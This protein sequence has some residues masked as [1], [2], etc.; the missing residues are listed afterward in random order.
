MKNFNESRVPDV[1]DAKVQSIEEQA[2]KVQGNYLEGIDNVEAVDLKIKSIDIKIQEKLN[3]INN[4]DEQIKN[5]AGLNVSDLNDKKSSL[6]DE[7]LLM[8][9][10]K[11][12][13]IGKKF[14]ILGNN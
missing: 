6:R 5:N 8:I 13:L 11:E 2:L 10:N 3:E 4:I 14:L 12:D 7:Y 9:K 1:N